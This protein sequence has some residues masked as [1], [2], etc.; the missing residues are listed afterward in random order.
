MMKA[1]F[2]APVKKKQYGIPILVPIVFGAIQLIGGAM[3]IFLKTRLIGATFV[4]VTFAISA[5]F[6]HK[7]RK[8]R[9]HN[10]NASYSGASW[11]YNVAN[12]G[13]RGKLAN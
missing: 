2:D 1:S 3:M 9:I 13:A 5:V 6:A 7:G 8:H 11:A 10:R 4:V 12:T